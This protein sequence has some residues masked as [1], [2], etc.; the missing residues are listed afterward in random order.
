MRKKQNGYHSQLCELPLYITTANIDCS[1]AVQQFVTCI[2]PMHSRLGKLRAMQ[3]NRI[4]DNAC[5]RYCIW[6]RS[7][8][9]QQFSSTLHAHDTAYEIAAQQFSSTLHAHD[10]A[11][12]IAAQQFSSALH[13][14]DTA[15]GIAV[16]QLSSSAVRYIHTILH[17]GSQ[18]S[19]SA[20]QQFGTCTRYCIW[21]RSSAAKQFSSSA[22]Q[23]FGTCTRYCIWDRSSAAQQ[24]SSSAVHCMHKPLHMGSQFHKYSSSMHAQDTAKW[25]RSS[26][27]EQHRAAAN[28]SHQCSISAVQVHQYKAAASV[29]ECIC[30]YIGDEVFH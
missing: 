17:M 16:Q 23:Q 22:V 26:T 20:V 29:I 7:S 15:Y 27:A 9:A 5:T 24:F 10:T 13:A 3:G 25:D 14:Q 21:D 1:S 12:E 4:M 8:A 2:L 11:Y 28:A 18:F 19:S 6:D 30:G